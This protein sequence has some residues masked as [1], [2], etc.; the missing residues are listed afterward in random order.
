MEI[1]ASK[2]KHGSS[3]IQYLR[4]LRTSQLCTS[5]KSVMRSTLAT[6]MA[7]FMCGRTESLKLS[8][9]AWCSSASPVCVLTASTSC[10]G[11]MKRNPQVPRDASFLGDSYLSLPANSSPSIQ[12]PLR[13]VVELTLNSVFTVACSF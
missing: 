5:M 11:A 8:P 9:A 3:R 7:L 12:N 6:G 10:G 2:R 1:H 4:P 13:F